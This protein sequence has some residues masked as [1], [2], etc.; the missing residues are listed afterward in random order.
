MPLTTNITTLFIDIGEALLTNGWGRES[1]QLD[2]EKFNLDFNDFD[3]M[4][5]IA[6]ETYELGKVTM[7]EY[8][9]IAVFSVKV[10]V[11][12]TNEEEMI[13]RLV[14]KILNHSNDYGI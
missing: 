7:D 13:A 6:F 11:I 9:D 5:A 3:S 1:R 2:A 10:N 12:K 8:L 14:S 4:H